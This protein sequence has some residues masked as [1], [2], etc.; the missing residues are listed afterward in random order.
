[1]CQ[2]FETIKI[3]GGEPKNLSLHDERMNRS[4]RILFGNNAILR[5]S[6]Y[7]QV[8]QDAKTGLIRCRVIYGSS[9][10]SIEYF[11]YIPADIKTLKLVKADTLTYDLK[12]LDRSRLTELINKSIAD[13]ILIVKEGCITDAS[14]ANIVFTDGKLWVT[15]DTPLLCGTMREKLL[16][17]GVINAKRITI[18]NISQF[19][20]F[21]L[22]NAMLDFSSRLLPI[23]NII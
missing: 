19:T 7:I 18:H 20:H 17:K 13:D 5:L 11:P 22:I 2:L 4:R 8:P 1:M 14:F 15:P 6:E 9:I 16:I 12:Y 10:K 23:S 21:R 3:I